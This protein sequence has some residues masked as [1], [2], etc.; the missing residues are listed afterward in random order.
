VHIEVSGITSNVV[1][2]FNATKAPSLLVPLPTNYFDMIGATNEATRRPVTRLDFSK[3]PNQ[4]P[5]SH[6][7]PAKRKPA[8]ENW[9]IK[10]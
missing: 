7:P 4:K 10:R 2:F 5:A 1:Y 8:L 3:L 9:I 6:P